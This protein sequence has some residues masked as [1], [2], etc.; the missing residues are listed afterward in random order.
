M[1]RYGDRE[2]VLVKVFR[3]TSYTA[4]DTGE[5]GKQ[6]ELVEVRSQPFVSHQY[7]DET[8][9]MAQSILTQIQ[10]MGLFPPIPKEINYPKVIL[11]LTEK[12]FDQLGVP[13]NVNDTYEMIFEKEK[14]IFKLPE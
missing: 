11:F 2:M 4:P 12:E 1:Y 8:A 3:I 5:P 14:I 10:S 7:G 9:R 6:I 13:M